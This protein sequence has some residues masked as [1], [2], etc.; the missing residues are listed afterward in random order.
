[1]AKYLKKDERKNQIK[2][3]AIELISE[4][5]YRNTSVQDILDKI[6]Y[7]KGGFYNCYK[8]K[9]ELFEEILQDAAYHRFEQIKNYKKISDL[10]RQTVLVEALLDKLMDYNPYKKM[11][12]TLITEMRTNE[13]LMD[14]HLRYREFMVDFFNDFF[15]RE[16]FEEYIKVSN[17]EFGIFIN[18]II[19]GVDIFGAYDNEEYRSLLKTIISSYFEKIGLFD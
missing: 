8:S 1:M 14:I 2:E 7:S 13:Y 3:A 5:G 17:K 10:D 4:H 15:K 18:S 6:N 12:S 16:G 11:F 19:L 9:E